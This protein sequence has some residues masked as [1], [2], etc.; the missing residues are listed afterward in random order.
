MSSLS[1]NKAKKQER[2]DKSA[3]L[4]TAKYQTILLTKPPVSFQNLPKYSPQVTKKPLKAFLC[5]VYT[6]VKRKN[7]ER[8]GKRA[9]TSSGPKV[10][11]RSIAT[12]RFF[13]E[14][15]CENNLVFEETTTL[16]LPLTFE[17]AFLS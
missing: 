3:P 16:Y 8:R 11:R 14:K 4:C 6:K 5:L 9:E 15:N 17:E 1:K 2:K 7:Q 12:G 10:D 13:G